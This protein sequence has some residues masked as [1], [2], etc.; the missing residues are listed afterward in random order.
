M[1]DTYLV[2]ITS[3]MLALL[4]SLSKLDLNKKNIHK[5]YL[6]WPLTMY[7]MKF[8]IKLFINEYAMYV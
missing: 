2:H 6:I 5:K 3:L 4:E 7:F 1:I 8:Y